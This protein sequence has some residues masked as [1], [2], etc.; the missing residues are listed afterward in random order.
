MVRPDFFIIGAPKCGTTALSE[1][2]RQ[3]P[4]IGF[5]NPKEPIYFC[6]DF[7]RLRNFTEEADYLQSCFGQ[8]ADPGYRAVGEGSTAY[9]FSAA[10]PGN[11]L[12]FAPQARFIVMLR[13]PLEMI[14][15]YH[16]QMLLGLEEDVT[17]FAKAWA[18]QPQR[19][20]GECLPKFNQEPALLQ[21][22]RLGRLGAHLQRLRASIPA[23]RLK[24]ILFDDLTADTRRVY[25]EVLAFL[26]IPDDGRTEFPRINE[27]QTIRM[28]GLYQFGHRPPG[29][30]MQLV[31]AGKRLF[32]IERLNIVPRMLAWNVQ[33]TQRP[34]LSPGMRQTLLAEFGEDIDLLAELLGRD[35]AHWK[36]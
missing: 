15:A 34:L 13:N 8:C 4:E 1:Y 31:S 10:A 2:L 27:S 17:D 5:S 20:R 11:I 16:A 14:P 24:T 28:R 32:G 30:L 33:K 19:A 7:P 21:Y 12:A 9:F 3:H 18:L 29:R 22:A 36:A 25:A 6:T 26:D 23:G 35:L